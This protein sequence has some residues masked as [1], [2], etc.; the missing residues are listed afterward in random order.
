MIKTN[1]RFKLVVAIFVALILL[2]MSNIFVFFIS[3]SKT[4]ALT[5][6][7]VA[8][9]AGNG[10]ELWDSIESNFNS[11]VVSDLT[12]KLFG[13]ENPV[14]YIKKM[15]DSQTNSYVVPASAIN[16]KVGSATEGLVLKLGGYEWIVA[17]LTLA[18]GAKAGEEDIVVTLYMA[19]K[20]DVNSEFYTSNA[21]VKGNNAYSRSVL[22]QNLLANFSQFASGN[23]AEKYLVQP[24]KIKYQHTQSWTRFG[25]TNFFNLS[26]DALHHL[27]S[28]W[29]S[30]PMYLPEDVFTDSNGDWVRYDSW[31][32]DYIWVPSITEVGGTFATTRLNNSIWDLSDSQLS[33]SAATWLRS[34]VYYNKVLCQS[35]NGSSNNADVTNNNNIR[36]AIHLNLSTVL[37]N[38]T[39]DLD[40][41]QDLKSVYNGKAQM[42]SE[43]ATKN[44]NTSWYNKDLYGVDNEFIELTYPNSSKTFED[45]GEYWVKAQIK[46]EWIDKVNAEIV[47]DSSKYN[48][49]EDQISAVEKLRLPKFKGTPDILD[50]NHLE[51]E[52]VRWIK[53][54]IEK[55]EIDFSKVVW[56]K[57]ELEYN[58]LNQSIL[59]VSGYPNFLTFTYSN[60]SKNEIGTYTAQVVGITSS[61][62]NYKIPTSTEIANYPTLKHTWQITKKKINAQWTNES[63][64]QDG[65]TISLPVLDLGNITT[66]EI[67]Y[68]YYKNSAMTEKTTLNEIFAEFDLTKVKTYWVKAT[69]KDSGG[70][71]NSTNC[72]F[73]SNGQEVSQLVT[74]LQTGSTANSVIVAITNEKVVFNNGEQQAIFSVSGGGLTANDL[75]VSYFKVD[76]TPLQSA[77]KN[78]GKYKVSVELRDDLQNFIIVGKTQFDFEIQS[79]KIKKPLASQVQFFEEDG[80]ELSDVA[81][82]PSNWKTYFE[83]KVYD[84]DN[85]EIL[86]VNDNWNFVNVN[87]YRIEIIFKDGTNT[88]NGCVADNVIWSD[89]SKNAFAISLE[90]MPLVFNMLGWQESS[91]NK[92]P[93]IFGANEQ[94]IAKYFD[95]VIYEM[96]NGIVVGNMLP[97]DAVLQ[98]STNYQISL[99]VKDEFV[100]NVFIKVNGVALNETETFIFK[101]GDDANSSDDK[102]AG[103]TQLWLGSNG[104]IPLLVWVLIVSNVL[105]I[106]LL[107]ILTIALLLGKKKKNLST[108]IANTKADCKNN[109][110]EMNDLGD[111]YVNGSLVKY[112]DWTFIVREKDILNIKALEN[113]NERVLMYAC[114]ESEVKKLKKFKTALEDVSNEIE[115]DNEKDSKSKGK[116]KSKK[117]K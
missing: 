33:T 48:W 26:N 62:N 79:L 44:E 115:S 116:K 18:D 106:L 13:N 10:A 82:M 4:Y 70:T 101:T 60:N 54:T 71:F 72:T 12:N 84:K 111:N 113:K 87:N 57:D 96:K 36:P 74:T 91:D 16:A 47:S 67:E 11:Y 27:N 39:N 45:A 109:V 34:G 2:L 9:K 85:N 94:E 8:V 99:K 117:N 32:E 53:I 97:Q 43:I 6:S 50:S 108:S 30:T 42:L 93:T 38:L 112:N 21:D 19:D 51:T 102:G 58:G 20:S 77:P 1:M 35:T 46:K 17:A 3:P 88:S 63:K 89:S 114:R 107:I 103:G 75:I 86:P 55:A 31:G 22:R 14:Q 40:N 5:N 100:G 104:K 95:Y 81:N 92:K 73:V 64:T 98:Y 110:A 24:K 52:T 105:T 23:F 59:I 29:M 80:F 49:T 15:V 66:A 37:K 65:I 41:P 61:N 68:N 78:A 28:G 25:E 7:S 69:L 56:G 90:I 76:G 83:I